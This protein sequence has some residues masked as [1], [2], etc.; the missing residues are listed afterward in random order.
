MHI[1]ADDAAFNT[2]TPTPLLTTVEAAAYLGVAPGTLKN[3]RSQGRAPRAVIYKE[4][5]RPC[6]RYS[7]TAL[8]QF[9]SSK[10]ER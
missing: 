9:I 6:I 7:K 8:D 2:A 4:S 5:P 10:E 3:W 1:L